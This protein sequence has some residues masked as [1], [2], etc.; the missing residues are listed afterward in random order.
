MDDKSRIS[1][2]VEEILDSSMT[3]EEACRECPEL[4]PAVRVRLER[5]RSV[6]ACLVEMFP[7]QES[8][9]EASGDVV[10]RTPRALPAIAGYEVQDTVGTGGMGVVYRAR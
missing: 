6:D 2:L 8:S 10:H 4:L 7:P 9:Q 1:A 3:L 5:I